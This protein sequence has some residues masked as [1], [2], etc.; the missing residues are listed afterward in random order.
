M[1]RISFSFAGILRLALEHHEDDRR[2]GREAFVPAGK[3]DKT[4]ADSTMLGRRML[5]TMP[6]S[7]ATNCSPSD[8]GVGVDVGPAPPGRALDA[9]VGETRARPDLSFARDGQA[10]RIRVIRVAPFFIQA[11]ARLVAKTRGHHCIAGRFAD[12]LGQ[13][14]AVL[15]LLLDR[16]LDA[17]H[18]LWRAENNR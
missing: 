3:R 7:A 4:S 2:R 6:V 11:F 16:E 13:L 14:G 15:D 10:E 1:S 8:F 12:S 5:R 17:G 18:F 9:E